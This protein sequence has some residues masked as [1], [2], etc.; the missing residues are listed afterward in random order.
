MKT[1]LRFT[2][3]ILIALALSSCYDKD[4]I[5]IIPEVVYE[6]EIPPFISL[7]ATSSWLLGVPICHQ[8]LLISFQ[9][10]SG[11]DLLKGI[12]FWTGRRFDSAHGDWIGYNFWDEIPRGELDLYGRLKRELYTLEYAYDDI[13]E[14]H[15]SYN[16]I[17]FLNGKL[18]SKKYSELNGNY[19]YLYFQTDGGGSGFDEDGECYSFYKKVTFKLS[20]PYVFG[21]DAVHIIDTWWKDEKYAN[22]CSPVCYYIEVDGKDVEAEI[23][24]I[25][26]VPFI[27]EGGS[28]GKINGPYSIA[29]IVL[30]K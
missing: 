25:Y 16:Q 6:I 30:D 21:D 9:D 4:K 1:V 17:G 14:N 12:E 26:D 5:E 11:N 15:W 3:L 18:F 24:Y 23:T 19:D 22:M 27:Y 13:F 29:M 20:C 10:A 8:E 2:S 7:N 28:Y